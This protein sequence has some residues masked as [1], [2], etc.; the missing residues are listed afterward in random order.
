MNY[1]ETLRW[2]ER[3]LVVYVL[4]FTHLKMP[5]DPTIM[6]WKIGHEFMLFPRIS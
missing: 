6:T 1:K 3:V 5:D 4:E 2:C